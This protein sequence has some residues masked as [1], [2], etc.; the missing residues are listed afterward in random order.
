MTRRTDEECRDLPRSPT[1][2]SMYSLSR[3]AFSSFFRL[4]LHDL[5]DAATNASTTLS[6]RGSNFD[7]VKWTTHA[8][9]LIDECRFA[10]EELSGGFSDQGRSIARKT[11]EIVTLQQEN[12]TLQLDNA[13]LKQETG[14]STHEIASLRQELAALRQEL[15]EV[16]RVVHISDRDR[17]C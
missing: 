5:Q 1:S 9:S 14:T 15:T 6:T 8:N 3:T 12:A 2:V 7:L 10:Q 4:Q 16:S 11:Q 13:I 17:R